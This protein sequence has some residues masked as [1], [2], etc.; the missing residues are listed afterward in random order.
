M[1]INR[2]ILRRAGFAEEMVA[3][4]T[5]A[6]GS[7]FVSHAVMTAI[8][9]ALP[10]SALDIDVAIAREIN[11]PDAGADSHEFENHSFSV[12]LRTYLDGLEMQLA[13]NGAAA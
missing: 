5:R 3:A 8:L 11:G 12:I 2:E 7:L 1:E 13:R 10:Q 9:V 4:Q 6:I